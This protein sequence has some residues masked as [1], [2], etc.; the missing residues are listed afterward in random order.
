MEEGEKKEE[1]EANKT[2]G[3]QKDG[4]IEEMREEVTK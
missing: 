4:R 1:T 2:K 3:M